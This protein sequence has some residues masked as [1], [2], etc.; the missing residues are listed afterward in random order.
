MLS[1]TANPA[2]F[3]GCG[4]GCG[5]GSCRFFLLSLADKSAADRGSTEAGLALVDHGLVLVVKRKLGALGDVLA[6][7]DADAGQTIDDPFLGLAI[8]ITRVIDEARNITLAGRIEH[9]VLVQ[10]EE[11]VMLEVTFYFRPQRKKW[12]ILLYRHALLI[13]LFQALPTG[14][15]INDF[16]DVLDYQI[17]FFHVLQGANAPTF[18]AGVEQ[19]DL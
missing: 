12:L 14:L 11:I 9:S 18:A 15:S 19:L 1:R 8:W 17:A 4:G 2:F 6:S 7:V 10:Q 3:L 16:A 5:R 13:R